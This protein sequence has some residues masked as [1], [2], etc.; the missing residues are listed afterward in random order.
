M[1]EK[2]RVCDMRMVVKTNYI[3]QLFIKIVNF[4]SSVYPF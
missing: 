2:Q 4:P 3:K 1:K